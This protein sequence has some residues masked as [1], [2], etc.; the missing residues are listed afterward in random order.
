MEVYHFNSKEWREQGNNATVYH[1]P[2]YMFTEPRKEKYAKI[3]DDP[4][5]QKDEE[6]I[7]QTTHRLGQFWSADEKPLF[8]KA[9]KGLLEAYKQL[10]SP[11]W[12]WNELREKGF[13]YA[14]KIGGK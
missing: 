14:E 11:D 2:T 12:S 5:W 13:V 8:V 4:A 9:P 1:E 6:T 3:I 10:T 7:R